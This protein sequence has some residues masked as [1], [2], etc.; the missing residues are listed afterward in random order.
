[1]I[2]DPFSINAEGGN[3]NEIFPNMFTPTK[4]INHKTIAVDL[5]TRAVDLFL[6]N[7]IA[8]VINPA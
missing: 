7:Y 1:M 8:T 6:F 5:I 3:E 2:C 4:G